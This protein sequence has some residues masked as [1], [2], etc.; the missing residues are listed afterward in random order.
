MYN[1][2]QVYRILCYPIFTSN[3]RHVFYHAILYHPFFDYCAVHLGAPYSVYII[4]PFG[5]PS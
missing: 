2:V 1:V 3:S 5:A 4:M